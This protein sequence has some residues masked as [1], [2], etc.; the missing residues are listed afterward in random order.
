[1]TDQGIAELVVQLGR[2]PEATP[3]I[4]NLSPVD[5]Q[6]VLDAVNSLFRVRAYG[7][8]SVDEFVSDVCEA[9]R[10]EGE[11]KANDE[12]R[13]RDRLVRLLSV[14]A[15]DVGAKAAILRVEY[16]NVFCD[17]RILT[18]VRPVYGK[19]VSAAPEAMIIMHTLKI[20]YH[21]GSAGGHLSEFYVALS[22]DEIS[23]L[24]AA[25]DRAEEKEKSLRS[26]I[27]VSKIRLIE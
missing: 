27:G 9:L 5:A 19:S 13:F 1:M 24:R 25:L 6:L 21:R 26:V 16:G 12:S 2:S 4:T 18:D 14:E 10:E 7:D 22:P 8:V 23:D 17:A 20:A 11:L 15:L 3:S